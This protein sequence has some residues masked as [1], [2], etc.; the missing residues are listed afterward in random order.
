M[1]Y[2]EIQVLLCVAHREMNVA[3]VRSLKEILNVS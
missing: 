2:A 1:D 3:Y